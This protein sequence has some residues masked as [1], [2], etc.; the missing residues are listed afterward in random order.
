M[1]DSNSIF[2]QSPTLI[3]LLSVS[4]LLY[5]LIGFAIT[6]LIGLFASWM[7]SSRSDRPIDSKLIF[8]L[9]ELFKSKSVKVS[10]NDLK[11]TRYKQNKSF[12]VSD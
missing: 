3:N 9:R 7:T 1:D 6:W 10:N 8:N 12:I 11:E 5:T 2:I 4:Y